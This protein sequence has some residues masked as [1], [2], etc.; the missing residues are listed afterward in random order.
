MENV[1]PSRPMRGWRKNTGPRDPS[2]IATAIAAS[3]GARISRPS[4]EP[5]TSRLR[6]ISRDDRVRPK[7]ATPSTR[8]PSML[9]TTTDEPTISRRRGSTLTFSPR[10]LTARTRLSTSPWSVLRGAMITRWISCSA[11]SWA[12]VPR[13]TSLS[14]IRTEVTSATTSALTVALASIFWRALRQASGSPS[15]RQRSAGVVRRAKPRAATR[16]P[17][18]EKKRTNHR[19]STWPPPSAPRRSGSSA[20]QS[21]SAHSVANWKSFGASSS[22]DLRRTS[23]SRSYRPRILL[24]STTKGSETSAPIDTWSPDP[25]AAMHIVTARAHAVTSASASARR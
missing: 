18:S 9:S 4:A 1:W 24:V 13:G 17:I 22:V 20:I 12:T 7:R 6:L 16:A 23:S 5:A 11:A 15:S 10:D 19:V 14:P 2:L 3:T 8:S 25:S 21:T